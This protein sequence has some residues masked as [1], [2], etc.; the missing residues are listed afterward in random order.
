L[1][2]SQI[3][4][5]GDPGCT[6]IADTNEREAGGAQCDD[7]V[8]NDSDGKTDYRVTANAGD[9]DCV[10]PYDD[11]E[12]AGGG[13]SGGCNDGVDNDANG[14]TDY[15]LDPGCTS[16]GDADESGA[17]VPTRF[18]SPVFANTVVL[19]G[20]Q[21]PT[22]D[23]TYNDKTFTND[24]A[25][26]ETLIAQNTNITVNRSRFRAREGMKIDKL[27][28]ATLNW[29]YI[30]DIVG[31]PQFGDHADGIQSYAAAL[32]FNMYINHSTLKVSVNSASTAAFFASDGGRPAVHLKEVL[33]AGGV[34]G[35]RFTCGGW[36]SAELDGVYCLSGGAFGGPGQCLSFNGTSS[37]PICPGWAQGVITKWTNV[38]NV[39]ISGDQLIMGT[40]IPAPCGPLPCVPP[41]YS[42]GGG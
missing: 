28:S 7:T 18:D 34:G 21:W 32:G 2:D 42:G 20:R 41:D 4:G 33:I 9:A 22:V 23:T 39:T 26:E 15:P 11:V 19:N 5:V 27:G 24:G 1:L 8:D 25:G 12:L 10:S 16:S 13:G 6:S 14:L 36:A 40:A 3:G 30:G 29:A 31:L 35:L 37:P 38:R 17:L